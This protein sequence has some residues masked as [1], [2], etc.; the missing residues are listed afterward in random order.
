VGSDR[1]EEEDDELLLLDRGGGDGDD[2]D[3]GDDN[4]GTEANRNVRAATLI[5]GVLAIAAGG[6]GFMVDGVGSNFATVI[7]PFPANARWFRAIVP[8]DHFVDINIDCRLE[9]NGVNGTLTQTALSPHLFTHGLYSLPAPRGTNT[10]R[11]RSSSN[12]LRDAM[13]QH[14]CVSECVR[15]GR[16]MG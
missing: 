16:W 10:L 14:N 1:I 6:G 11:S 5:T 12:S 3:G 2:D 8:F 7:I 4:E 13:L 9:S 15:G